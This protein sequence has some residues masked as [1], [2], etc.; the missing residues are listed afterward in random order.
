MTT[1]DYCVIDTETTLNCHSPG[2]FLGHPMALE[3]YAPYFGVL[4]KGTLYTYTSAGIGKDFYAGIWDKL[5]ALKIGHNIKF[6]LL[7]LMRH[8]CKL[9]KRTLVWDTQLAEYILSGQVHRWSTLDDLSVKYGGEVKPSSIKELFERGVGA[10]RINR[11]LIVPYLNGDLVNTE[12]VF[13]GQL[14]RAAEDGQLA[15]I[16]EM[17]D[18]LL[19]TTVMQYNGIA[20]NEEHLAYSVKEYQTKLTGQQIY[21]THLLDDI[22]ALHK[23]ALHVEYP[24][25]VKEQVCNVT[26][27]KMLSTL[28]FGGSVKYTKVV[29]AGFYKNGK[30]KFKKE[31]VIHKF[32]GLESTVLHNATPAGAKKDYY[33]TD[34]N[35]L[36]S[37][38]NNGLVSETR[39]LA[40]AV[41][42]LRNIE[43]T[44]STYLIKLQESCL[45]NADGLMYVHPNINH[46]A[47]VTGRL[48]SSA[49]NLQNQNNEGP[50]KTCFTSRWATGDIVEIDYGQ[51]EIV[52]LAY[53]TQDRQLLE[54]L[55]H[56]VDMHTELYRSMYGSPPTAAERK[57]FKRL[58]FGLIY[59]AGVDTLAENAGVPKHLARKFVELFYSRYGGVAAYH[60]RIVEEAKEHAVATT[61][62]VDG[63]Q[64]KE[65]TLRTKTGRKYVFNTYLND[66]YDYK[67][68][69]KVPTVSFSPPELKNYYVQGF[70]TGDI[71]PIVLGKIYRWWINLPDEIRQLVLPVLTVHD[72]IVFDTHPTYREWAINEITA[73]MV[74]VKKHL[75]ALDIY[76]FDVKIGVG[77]SVGPSWGETH[78]VRKVT[79]R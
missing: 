59:G 4:E 79:C 27:G 19:A 26:S 67:L 25:E 12:K 43:K 17:M 73:I 68:K 40:A 64:M 61:K 30:E 44:L 41:L 77:V 60:D 29:P 23:D 62:M 48:S 66:R 10:D 31:E 45:R 53:I 57:P 9:D 28:F 52:G 13:L 34:E 15:L 54:D 50:V 18:A 36:K 7:Y 5:P 1:Y 47:T 35:V 63:H 74:D 51:L 20:V 49:P 21:I 75:E 3:N 33:T 55:N 65:Y 37:I 14:R 24:K 72:S 8:G 16:M 2:L 22:F 58:S 6:D 76:D 69:K 56:D 38:A 71:V 70:S 11:E 46:C 39:R 78:E 42:D 32:G